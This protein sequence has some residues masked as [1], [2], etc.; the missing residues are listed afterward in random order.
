MAG[1]ASGNP[2]GPSGEGW[3]GKEEEINKARG[4]RELTKSQRRKSGLSKF[5]GN[6]HT[7]KGV[8][9]RKRFSPSTEAHGCLYRS[10]RAL[11]ASLS[12]LAFR[13]T[14]LK[15]VAGSQG[16]VPVLALPDTGHSLPHP[17]LCFF[18]RPMKGLPPM[19]LTVPLGVGFCLDLVFFPFSSYGTLAMP[20]L[21]AFCHFLPFVKI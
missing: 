8:R 9:G 16:R 12:A 6:L 3:P 13:K 20:R 4:S 5:K 19:I 10:I 2:G 1:E 7:G 15:A 14:V 18:I 17:R 11:G 21:G